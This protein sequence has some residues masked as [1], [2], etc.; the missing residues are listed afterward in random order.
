MLFRSVATAEGALGIILQETPKTLW[1]SRVLVVGF[2]HVGKLVADR[3][4]VLGAEVWVS[5]RSCGD[6]A[7]I[8]ALGMRALDTRT[9]E[10]A[11]ARF[12]VVVNTVPALVFGEARLRE[13]KGDVLCVDLA[14]K[15]GGLD[16]EAAGALGLHAIWAL[17]LP[18]QVA[19]VSAGAMIRD[20]VLNIMKEQTQWKN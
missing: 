7:W 11:L 14:S 3:L 6:R 20:T 13:L 5:A 2:G 19:P 16:F 1:R 17:S 8:E 9:L 18:G 12:D 15:P 4:K 10:G